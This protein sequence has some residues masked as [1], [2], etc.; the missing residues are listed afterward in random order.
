L[1]A[2]PHY[3]ATVPDG[4]RSGEGVPSGELSREGG[5]PSPPLRLEP[6]ERRTVAWVRFLR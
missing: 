4:L 1:I 5:D 6:G 3:L 2:Y